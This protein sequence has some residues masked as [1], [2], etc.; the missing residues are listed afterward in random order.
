MHYGL[1]FDVSGYKFDKH[2]FYDLDMA[3]CPP[4]DLS[5]P[6]KRTGGIFDHPPRP[7]TLTN[8]VKPAYA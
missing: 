5:D 7:S 2:W 3:N 8:K 1:L 6:K 4:W